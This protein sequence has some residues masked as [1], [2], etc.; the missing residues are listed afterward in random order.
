MEKLEF[1]SDEYLEEV[2]QASKSFHIGI[3]VN[4]KN[5]KGIK[6]DLIHPCGWDF[7]SFLYI[8]EDDANDCIYNYLFRIE[9]IS[10]G[11][12]SSHPLEDLTLKE[13]LEIVGEN[14]WGFEGV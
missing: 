3:Y 14:G 13:I 7:I 4:Y 6:R 1:L 2:Y 9:D 12:Y 5:A 10:D 8:D 11:I